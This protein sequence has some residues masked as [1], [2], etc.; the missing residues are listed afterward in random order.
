MTRF[1]SSALS[2]L[3]RAPVRR[4]ALRSFC[5]GVAVALALGGCDV[6]PNAEKELDL[7]RREAAKGNYSAAVVR[8]K[9]VVQQR[10]DDPDL[11]M[12][13]GKVELQLG[14]PVAAE[15]EFRRARELNPATPESHLY[16]VRSLVEQGAFQRVMEETAGGT[17]L[18]PAT[19]AYRGLAILALGNISQ[20]ENLFE[21]AL[22]DAPGLA[23]ARLGQARAAFLRGESDKALAVTEE[24]IAQQPADREALLTKAEVLSLTGRREQAIDAYRAV[25]AAYPKDVPA[26]V[27]LASLLAETGRYD[28]A[29]AAVQA[30]QNA[31]PGHALGDYLNA[32]IAYRQGDIPVARQRIAVA[33]RELPR[34]V[35]GLVLAGMVELAAKA[36]AQAITPLSAAVAQAPDHVVARLTL[37]RAFIAEHQ[38]QQAYDTLRPL[39][40]ALPDSAPVLALAGEALLN[41]NEPRRAA[42]LLEKA[43]RARPR[44]AALTRA[45]AVSRW[46]GGDAEAALPILGKDPADPATRFLAGVLKAVRAIE[47]NRPAA[48]GAELA[49]LA[50]EHPES[51]MVRNLQGVAAARAGKRVDARTSFEA[52][53]GLDPG[54]YPALVNLAQLDLREG[55]RERALEHIDALLA[56][57]PDDLSGLLAKAAIAE[58]AGVPRETA[59]AALERAR[60]AH[61]RALMP[62]LLSAQ[63]L[64]EDGEP[65]RALEA[66]RQ[67][68]GLAPGDPQV[69]RVLGLAQLGAGEASAASATFAQW[70]AARPRDATPLLALARAQFAEGRSVSGLQ[71][72]DQALA[73]DPRAPAVRIEAVALYVAAARLPDAERQLA[74]LKALPGAPVAAV[75]EAEGDLRSA[76]RKLGLAID[77]Y[78]RAQAADPSTR[79]LAKLQAALMESGRSEEALQ[80]GLQW[81]KRHP[82]DVAARVLV[83]DLATRLGRHREAAEQYER[84]AQARPNELPVLNNL[85]AA[86]VSFDPKRAVKVAESAQKLAPDDPLVNDTYGWALVRSGDVEKGL[87]LI[88]RSAR[89]LP[90]HPDIAYHYAAA[91]AAAGDASAARLRLE[92]AL[93]RKV[94]FPEEAQARALLERLKTAP[95]KP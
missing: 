62:A 37:A 24:L 54:Y 88:E 85:A 5:A 94:P 92:Q 56:R 63:R 33:N 83:A 93:A 36:P 12:M 38:P 10:P 81:L 22:A 55:H 31:A 7:A 70:A 61:P 71:S 20:A 11:R 43:Q 40:E 9:N 65:K 35:P 84:V 29:K 90:D 79:R 26:H 42:D 49:R 41:M 2:G 48:A 52:A 76:E 8:L 4:R 32:L 25:L 18:E 23:V 57:R 75:A 1:L 6:K 73:L 87:R 28:E 27:R 78:R 15:K 46:L 39:M 47:A 91:L 13:L 17:K 64:L 72:L 95:P 68:H 58:S 45:L 44:D 80:S 19:L 50:Q 14:D 16:L 30:L 69:L 82:E 51:A 34:F 21:K 89:A 60:R 67:A 66:A 3:P 74:A 59:Q 77:A 53:L 86:Y